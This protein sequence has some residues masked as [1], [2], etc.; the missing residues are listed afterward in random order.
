MISVTVKRG[1]GDRTGPEIVDSMISSEAQAVQRGR[2]EI[3]KQCSNR[4]IVQC[5][6]PFRVYMRPGALVHV[7]DAEFGEY[8]AMLKQYSFD[9]KI[10]KKSYSAITTVNME[11]LIVNE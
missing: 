10:G 11:R 4:M 8:I 7:L 6:G 1:A 3:D 2:I 9:I 5:S